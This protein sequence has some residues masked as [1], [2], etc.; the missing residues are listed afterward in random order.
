MSFLNLCLLLA[1]AS[2]V[3]GIGFKSD[4]FYLIAAYYAGLGIM[5]LI[6]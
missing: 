1:L 3:M 4:R 6:P 5:E 2:L